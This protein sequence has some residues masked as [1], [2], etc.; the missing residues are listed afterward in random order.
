MAIANHKYRPGVYTPLDLLFYKVWWEP[1]SALVPP[2]MAPN[3][4]TFIGFTLALTNVPLLIYYNPTLESTLPSWVFAYCGFS[5]FFYLTMDAIDGMQA[6]KTKS[7]S[8]LGQLFDHG[9]DCAISTV[10]ALMMINGLGLGPDWRAVALVA[11]VQVAFFLSQWEEKYTGT[12]RTCIWGIFGVTEMQLL[13]MGQMFASA[14]NPN[15]GSLP[16]YPGWT[17]TDCFV[18]FYPGFMALTSTDCMVGIL[19]T[20]LSGWK[21]L[22][23]VLGLNGLVLATA[24]LC[25]AGFAPEQYVMAVLCLALC[26]SFSTIRVILSSISHEPFPLY[27]AVSVP[28]MALLVAR[29]VV[30]GGSWVTLALAIYLGGLLDHIVKALIQVIGEISSFLGIY[31][32]NIS[33]KRK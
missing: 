29:L 3:L 28:Y 6:R 23:S 15:M 17:Y 5:V 25:P 24:V 4:I 2:W 10:F 8:P 20:H 19:R 9:C 14:W 7:S 12:C 27:H 33:K 21:E 26:N 18:T 13:L 1:V 11:S 30:G 31:V 16:A 22:G 32:F